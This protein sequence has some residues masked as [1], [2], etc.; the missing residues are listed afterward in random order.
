MR[1]VILAVTQ[2]AQDSALQDN[3]QLVYVFQGLSK[4]RHFF[5]S[6]DFRITHPKTSSEHR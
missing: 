6:S 1:R 4:D 3:E 5:V 2:F